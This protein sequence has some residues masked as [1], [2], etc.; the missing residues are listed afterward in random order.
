MSRV[1]KLSLSVSANWFDVN[2]I[3]GCLIGMLECQTD[4]IC[5]RMGLLCQNRLHDTK[6]RSRTTTAITPHMTLK[7]ET[8]LWWKNKATDLS[9]GSS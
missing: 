8:N 2:S 9:L 3:P 6:R 1:L 5:T 4:L 7:P